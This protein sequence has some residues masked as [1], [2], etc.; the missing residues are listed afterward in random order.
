LPPA[1]RRARRPPSRAGAPARESANTTH[2]T[3]ADAQGRIAC[4]THRI[5]SLFGA[6]ILL[7]ESGLIPNNYMA[8]F[9]PVPGRAQSIAPGKRVTTSMSPLILRREGAPLAALGLP[10]G[11]RI[12][13]ST[14]QAVMN[15]LDH[16]MS[17]Q[18]AVEAPRLW[19]MGGAVEVEPGFDAPTRAALAALGHE[20]LAVPHV[21]GGMCAIGFDGAEMEGAACWRAD[22]S[23]A[24]LAGGWARPGVR[25]WPD[26]A[27]G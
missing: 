15:L 22:G 2:V 8:L 26:A 7:P 16:G 1:G 13:G 18:E 14:F 11:L 19:T 12:F 6:R 25:F 21:A 17:L 5:N 24:A 23:P 27:R 4:C 10:G 9:D 20:V 3:V